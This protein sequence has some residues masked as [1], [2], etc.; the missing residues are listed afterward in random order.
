MK[1][2]WLFASVLLGVVGQLLMKWGL[3]EPKPL[4]TEG[5]SFARSL[6]SWPVLAGLTAYACSSLFWLLALK[7]MPISVAYPMVSLGY[8][9]VA[10]AGYYLFREPLSAVHWLGIGVI[11]LGVVIVARA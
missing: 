10:L 2:L 1:F 8:V 5:P 6:S 9:G 4:W 11:M 7:Q 3:V